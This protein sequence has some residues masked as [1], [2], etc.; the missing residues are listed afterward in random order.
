M[1]GGLNTEN[2]KHDARATINASLPVLALKVEN[3][4]EGHPPASCE[5]E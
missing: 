4:C 5:G 3:L 1:L 2:V